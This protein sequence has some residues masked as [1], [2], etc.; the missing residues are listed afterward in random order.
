MALATTT[1]L[2][3]FFCNRHGRLHIRMHFVLMLVQLLQNLVLQSPLKEIELTHRSIQ[4]LEM[5]VLPTAERVKHP[6]GIRLEMRLL[7]KLHDHLSPGRGRLRNIL[8]LRLIRD[9]PVQ[10]P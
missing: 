2:F 9:K 6:L 8:L 4:T 10:K 1:R 3:T 7:R 5:N